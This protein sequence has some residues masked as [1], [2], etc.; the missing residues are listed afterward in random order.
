MGRDRQRLRDTYQALVTVSYTG[1]EAVTEWVAPLQF[2]SNLHNG[3]SFDG[4]YRFVLQRYRNSVYGLKLGNVQIHVMCKRTDL[5]DT[6]KTVVRATCIGK[7]SCD[8]ATR[9]DGEGRRASRAR[10]IASG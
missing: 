7:N 2:H 3:F 8:D 5:R 9:V 1:S 10:H 4:C 6:Q